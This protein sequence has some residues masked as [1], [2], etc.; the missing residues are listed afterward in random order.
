MTGNEVTVAA[1]GPTSIS[2]MVPLV[3]SDL[4]EILL[5]YQCHNKLII[6][7]KRIEDNYTVKNKK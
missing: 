3:W 1:Y 5:D 7:M 4:N 6:V 2:S